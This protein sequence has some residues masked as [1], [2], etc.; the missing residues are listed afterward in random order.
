MAEAELLG[1][2]LQRPAPRQV[3]Q[4]AFGGRHSAVRNTGRKRDPGALPIIAANRERTTL[5]G[6]GRL[7]IR[8]WRSF[9]PDVRAPR[10]GRDRA[11]STRVMHTFRRRPGV[12]G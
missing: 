9:S 2:R 6:L 11:D 4:R 10:P 7:V 1:E 12:R 5:N 3:T 8:P